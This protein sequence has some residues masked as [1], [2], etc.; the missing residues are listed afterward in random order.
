[1]RRTA[2]SMFGGSRTGLFALLLW[3]AAFAG[4]PAA[5]AVRDDAALLRAF[6]EHEDAHDLRRRLVPLGADSL[7]LLFRIA[8][9]GRLPA[10]G[11]EI[12]AALGSQEHAVVREVL[13]ILPRRALV[14]F[15]EELSVQEPTPP[16][17]LEAQRLLSAMGGGDHVRLLARLTVGSRDRVLTPALRSGFERA[18]ATILERDPLGFERLPAL[19][20]EVPATLTA[21]ILRAMVADPDPE[22]TGH[23]A[24]QLGFAPDLEVL[25]LTGIADRGR[26]DWGQEEA[27][28]DR[29]R[30]YLSQQDPLV[31]SAAARAA[32]RLEDDEAI[33]ALVELLSHP[34]VRVREAGLQALQRI[35]GLVLGSA[36]AAWSRWYAAELQFWDTVADSVLARLEREQ[37][38]EFVRA[39][40]ELMEHRLYRERTVEGLVRV[41]DRSDDL[42]VRLACQL[43]GS[44]GSPTALPALEECLRHD[45]PGVRQAAAAS[46]ARCSKARRER[47]RSSGHEP[48]APTE[49]P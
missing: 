23:L 18:L 46:L 38:V 19:V 4:Q 48:G 6:A 7:P 40:G 2:T 25:I 12:P 3:T 10:T 14:G 13:T 31:L 36:P 8:V 47:E 44:L 39:A 9:A 37:G 11:D 42:E 5:G 32:G 26:Q 22:G 45:D 30:R 24:D 29:V 33:P 15:L 1:M 34:E 21:S 17:R 49:R 43:L 20:R 27:V 41:L 16:M 35:T 28:R